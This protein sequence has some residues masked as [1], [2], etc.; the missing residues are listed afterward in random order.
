VIFRGDVIA[1]DVDINFNAL[2]NDKEVVASQI[3]PKSDKIMFTVKNRKSLE[4]VFKRDAGR[5]NCNPVG[6]DELKD[7]VSANVVS[8]DLMLMQI[9][10]SRGTYWTYIT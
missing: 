1:L 4:L 7:C 6:H 5:R 2:L 9:R 3:V 10:N 8:K